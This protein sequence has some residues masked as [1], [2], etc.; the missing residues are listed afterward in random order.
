MNTLL[1]EF[2]FYSLKPMNEQFPSFICLSFF[3]LRPMNDEFIA[4]GCESEGMS[5]NTKS[6]LSSDC[7]CIW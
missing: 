6:R 4:V 2:L 7:C 3:G 5:R 1:L